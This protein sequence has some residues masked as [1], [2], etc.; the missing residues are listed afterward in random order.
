MFILKP[1]FMMDSVFQSDCGF[2]ES[3]NVSV[4]NESA[5]QPPSGVEETEE[6]EGILS[7]EKSQS[8]PLKIKRYEGPRNRKNQPSGDGIAK[9][10]N[11]DFYEGSF[12]KGIF[13]G[14]GVLRKRNGYRY[15]G[16]FRKGL[17]HGHGTQT[18][19]DCSSYAGDWLKD[20]RH[21]Y[22]TY[23]FANKD[24]Y[25]GNWCLNKKHGIGAYLIAEN[26][27]RLRGSW[28]EGRLAGPIE[29]VFGSVRY[30]GMWDETGLSAEHDGVFNFASKYLL[31][32]RMTKGPFDE[33]FWTPSGVERYSFASLPLE[34]LPVPIPLMD[35]QDSSSSDEE[36]EPELQSEMENI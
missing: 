30:H 29:F 7:T 28:R 21:G 17:R 22:G 18:Y 24:L 6:E 8:I 16:A 13:H 4:A 36:S 25:E 34:P 1:D 31:R 27:L 33:F 10:T 15:V 9:F 2:F 26:G 19:P 12:R 5:L 11:G 20:S 3:P 23:K 35:R 14:H 32:G